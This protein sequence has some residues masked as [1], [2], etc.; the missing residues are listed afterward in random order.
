MKENRQSGVTKG[1]VIKWA[2][3]IPGK[4]NN[5]RHRCKASSGKHFDIVI[6]DIEQGRKVVTIIGKK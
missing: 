4:V 1:D 6:D 5:L 2:R 3:R